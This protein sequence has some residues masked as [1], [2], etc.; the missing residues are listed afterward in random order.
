MDF[1]EEEKAKN[2][3]IRK[4]FLINY[5]IWFSLISIILILTLVFFNRLIVFGKIFSNSDGVVQIISLVLYVISL[6]SLVIFYIVILFMIIMK[7]GNGY[8]WYPEISKIFKK[9]DILSFVLKCISVL[10]FIFVFLFNPCTVSGASMEDTF[11]NNDK[12]IVSSFTTIKNNDIVI[13]DAS[14]YSS[15]ESFYIKRVIAQEGDRINYID[16][17]LYVNDVKD[18]RGNITKAE[19]LRIMKSAL[20][21]SKLPSS[22]E[23]Q[24]VTIPDNRVLVLGDNRRNSSDSRYY[25]L[26]ARDDIYG[27]VLFRFFPFNEMKFY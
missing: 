10:L 22:D 18:E 13:F 24:E 16:D 25:G 4:K 12:I 14:N 7:R 1:L 23:I 19:Y 6:V 17:E 15:E 8:D 26:I 27:E 2:L 9:F 20:K 21:Y 3:R 11:Y 5:W